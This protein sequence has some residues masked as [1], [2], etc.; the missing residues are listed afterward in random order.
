[1]E[2]DVVL[3]VEH[4]GRLVVLV[5]VTEKDWIGFCGGFGMEIGD[6]YLAYLE[7]EPDN[8]HISHIHSCKH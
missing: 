5:C 1:M 7:P 3:G 2:L 4:G 8:T 6:T